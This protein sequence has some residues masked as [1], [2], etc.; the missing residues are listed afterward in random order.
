MKEYKPV[1]DP[2]TSMFTS[3]FL[4][5]VT[6]SFFFISLLNYQSEMT[7]L[8]LIV[9]GILFFTMIW[10]R[11]SVSNMKVEFKVDKHRVFPDE[12]IR[13]DVRAENNKLLPVWLKVT[14]KFTQSFFVSKSPTSDNC[15]LLWFQRS[16]FTWKLTSLKR[17]CFKIGHP[18]IA[19]SD[20]FGFFPKQ[21]IRNDTTDVIVF[22]KI[23][24]VRPF[25]LPEQK[26]FSIPGAQSPVLD[27]V[28]II[29]TR[30]Y[31]SS[32]PVRLI[33]WK[34]SARLCKLQ[35]KV[36]EPSIQGKVLLVVD[37]NLFFENQAEK[38]FERMLEATASM[39]VYFESNGN[40]V[41]FMTN[42]KI[43]GGKPG[44][45][46][47]SRNRNSL[48][49]ILETIARM[50]MEPECSLIDTFHNHISVLWGIN[51]IFCSY[52]IDE[53]ILKMKAFY[54]AKRIP[55]KYF[56]SSTD[57]LNE[58]MVVELDSVHKIDSV[59]L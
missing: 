6:L 11:F 9:L 42:A 58:D 48:P 49:M 22:P 38:E 29:G 32:T 46:P 3:R 56:V 10:S 35:E 7:V 17:G 28:Y 4:F 53:S 59:C 24:G 13:I 31:Q 55:V 1:S 39:A 27:P 34:A 45:V 21:Q 52:S 5:Y 47:L 41:G 15:F 19:V 57:A 12:E 36:C 14:L 8:T 44:F 20:L 30:D 16:S 2:L 40:A 26:F 23:S 43:A 33:Q 37:V 18:Q 25:S 51:C 54:T 50:E